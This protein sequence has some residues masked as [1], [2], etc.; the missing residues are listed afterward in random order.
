MVGKVC[1][2][3]ENVGKGMKWYGN[4]MDCMKVVGN[5][6]IKVGKLY[7]KSMMGRKPV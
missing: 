2:G 3:Y 5:V 1:E 7:E 4:C 6:Q